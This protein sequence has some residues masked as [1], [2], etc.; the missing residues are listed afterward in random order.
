MRCAP[1]PPLWLF[2]HAGGGCWLLLQDSISLLQ[3]FILSSWI[4]SVVPA[5]TLLYMMRKNTQA[6]SGLNVRRCS[7]HLSLALLL[8]ACLLG[9]GC[10]LS[11]S[12]GWRVGGRWLQQD[13]ALNGPKGIQEFEQPLVASAVSQPLNSRESYWRHHISSLYAPPRTRDPR[14]SLDADE[15]DEV[16]E[17]TVGG[18]TNPMARPQGDDMRHLSIEVEE[19]PVA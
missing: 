4:P 13:K 2:A 1:L 14:L 19:D 10:C 15:L 18:A 6:A 16:E 8:L 7:R 9:R 5:C 12:L 3:W 17:E 11:L